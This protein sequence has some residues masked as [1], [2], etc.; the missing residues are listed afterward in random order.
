MNNHDQFL[1]VY[2]LSSIAA[3]KNKEIYKN[4]ISFKNYIYIKI[5]VARFIVSFRRE[6]SDP[7]R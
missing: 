3:A 2:S 6:R 5:D 4:I 7:M 1:E